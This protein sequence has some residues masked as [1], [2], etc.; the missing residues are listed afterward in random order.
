[1]YFRAFLFFLFLK[2]INGIVLEC[3]FKDETTN[4]GVAYTCVAKNFHTS[5]DDRTVTEIKGQHL[6]SRTNDDVKKFYVFKQSCPYL[7]LN[8]S[9]FFKNLD[10][11]YIK[12]S[13]VQHVLEG[14][15]DGFTTIRIFDV[16]YNP[17]EE[18]NNG[19]FDGQTSIQIIAFYECHLKFISPYALD[20]LTNLQEGHFDKNVCIDYR[21]E[22]SLYLQ[23]EEVKASIEN[24]KKKLIESCQSD[25]Y[26]GIL[27]NK[28]SETMKCPELKPDNFKAFPKLTFTQRNANVIIFF[29]TVLIVVISVFA[30]KIARKEQNEGRW[31]ILETVTI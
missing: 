18:I 28:L 11:Y 15:L 27:L 10:I 30:V 1:M 29:L 22:S 6:L 4:W 21:S 19:V 8:A 25:S 24:L 14:D 2:S 3:D 12:Q 13:N 9:S 16:S 23:P 20:A 31:N 17:I 5:L 7:P 26:D